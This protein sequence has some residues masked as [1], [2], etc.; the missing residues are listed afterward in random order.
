MSKKSS[1]K[2]A[3]NRKLSQVTGKRG[4]DYMLAEEEG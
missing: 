4:R 1:N 3:G 2:A